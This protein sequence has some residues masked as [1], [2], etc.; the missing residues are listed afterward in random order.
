MT[1][2]YSTLTIR[3]SD[4]VTDVL[5]ALLDEIGSLGAQIIGDDPV[6]YVA[7]FEGGE[8]LDAVERVVRSRLA[9]E[10]VSDI[11]FSIDRGVL[12]EEDWESIWRQTLAPVRVGRE[13]LIRPSWL[14]SEPFDRKTIVV[15]P[16]MAFGTGTHATTQLCL[17][18]LEDAEV[19]AKDVLDIGTGT[20]IL[21]IAASL[22]GANSVTAV[23]VDP[24][25]VECAAENLRLNGC[26]ERVELI[27]GVLSDVTVRQYDLII[28][29]IEYR[30]L[31]RIA[32]DMTEYLSP[33]GVAIFS[34][35]LETERDAFL[36]D[37]RNAGWTPIR[38]RRQFDPMTDDG[39]I[40]VV[41]HRTV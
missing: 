13:W 9:D 37:I 11:E 18:E 34:G 35:I 26:A 6:E 32:G 16:K 36:R 38:V 31:A 5:D 25:A 20:G 4:R 17:I 10:G 33:S 1:D 30:T 24:V 14:S 22:L 39:W 12:H 40:S 7:Y 28:A 27:T 8:N 23:E 15:D 2:S 3:V 41:A 21:A 29:N 19:E